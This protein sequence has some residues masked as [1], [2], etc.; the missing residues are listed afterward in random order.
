VN[1]KTVDGLDEGL[2]D[3]LDDEAVLTYQGQQ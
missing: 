1:E 2:I 3:G